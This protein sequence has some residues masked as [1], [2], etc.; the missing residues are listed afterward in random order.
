MHI[1]TLP[2]TYFGGKRAVASIVWERLGDVKAYVEPFFGGGAVFWLRPQEHFASGERRWELLN[3]IDGMIVNFLRAVYHDPRGCGS[4]RWLAYYRSRLN[5]SAYLVGAP[6][7]ELSPTLRSRPRALRRQ[8]RRL[9]GLGYQQLDW[10][11]VVQRQWYLDAT[12]W[13]LGK[14]E[15]RRRKRD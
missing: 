1:E 12:R 8:D 13:S 11:R 14:E 5:S 3:D 2:Y 15:E 4:L 7:R 6:E 10:R 9:V